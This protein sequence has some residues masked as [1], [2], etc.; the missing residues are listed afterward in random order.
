[1]YQQH[2]IYILKREANGL[3]GGM[4]MGFFAQGSKDTRYTV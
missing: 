1:M 4:Y 3:V 2:I